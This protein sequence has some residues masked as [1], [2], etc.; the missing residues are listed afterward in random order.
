MN[1]FGYHCIALLIGL[2]VLAPA[3]ATAQSVAELETALKKCQDS[4]RKMDTQYKA[5]CSNIEEVKRRAHETKA[6]LDK[7]ELPLPLRIKNTRCRELWNE[8]DELYHRWSVNV[9]QTHLAAQISACWARYSATCDSFEKEKKDWQESVQRQKQSYDADMETIRECRQLEGQF[10]SIV[11]S[12]LA[13]EKELR[14]AKAPPPP[15]IQPASCISIEGP[16]TEGKNV[17]FTA[18][19]DQN[20]QGGS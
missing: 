18:I 19:P 11:E 8:C 12:C 7:N 15:P 2:S 5:W 1:M 17:V 16:R 14:A 4:W 20:T 9:T 3:P 10:R 6:L 13:I